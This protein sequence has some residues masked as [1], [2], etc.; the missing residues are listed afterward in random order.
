MSDNT[1]LRDVNFL[2]FD[3]DYLPVFE[4]KLFI[5]GTGTKRRLSNFFV[6]LVF[7]TIIATYGVLS[8]SSATVIGAMLIAPLMTPII[9][10]TTAVVMGS[11]PRALRSIALTA[12]GVLAVILIAYLLTWIVPDQ[13]ISFTNNQEISSRIN[14][15]LYAIVTALGAGAAGA[16]ITSRSEIA[17]AIGGVAIAVA[18]APPLCVVGISLQEGQWDAASGAFLLFLTNFMATLFAGGLVLVVIGLSKLGFQD[19]HS[20][21]RRF[22]FS[23]IILGTL[24]LIVPLAQ[25]GYSG[26]KHINEHRIATL[27]LQKWLEGTSY[28]VISVTVKD[29]WVDASVEGTGEVNSLQELENQLAEALLRRVDVDLQLIP[30]MRSNASGP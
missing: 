13:T 21:F 29:D 8:D 30:S 16:F 4:K 12:I 2:G 23:I 20:R 6:L 15:G 11:L 24:L 18:L 14:P 3:P 26:L 9:A 28:D 7:A 27:E 1:R 25:T 10:T 22:G 19:K 5:E 17:D